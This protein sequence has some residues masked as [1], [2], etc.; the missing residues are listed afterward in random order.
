M[1]YCYVLCLLICFG[2]F[3]LSRRQTVGEEPYIDALDLYNTLLIH[4]IPFSINLSA[5]IAA[6][7]SVYRPVYVKVL[8]LSHELKLFPEIS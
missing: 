4:C 2:E 5:C 3:V 1:N 7:L 6:R 8:T